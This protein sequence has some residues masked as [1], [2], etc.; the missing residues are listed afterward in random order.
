MSILYLDDYKEDATVSFMWPTVDANGESVKRGTDGTLR[1]YKNNG[2]AQKTTANGV[3]DDDEFDGLTGIQS[4]IIDTSNDTGDAGF[5]VAGAD[6]TV[7]VVGVIIDGKTVNAVLAHFSIENRFEGIFISFNA[8]FDGDGNLLMVA[9]IAKNGEV[10]T[11]ADLTAASFELLEYDFVTP[12]VTKPWAGPVA[13]NLHTATGSIF[14]KK[15]TPGI[16]PGNTYAMEIRVTFA[17]RQ[18][19][20]IVPVAVH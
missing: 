6:Y 4:C 19:L 11:G 12:G 17:G 14:L 13:G 20:D 2:V 15:A 8:S 16:V 9:S 18:Y 5:W 10:L 1:I 7:I 3:T